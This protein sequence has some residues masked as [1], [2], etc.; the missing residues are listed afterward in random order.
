[1]DSVALAQEVGALLD[2][3]ARRTEL[4]RRGM[5]RAAEFTWAR[6]ARQTADASHRALNAG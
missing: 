1:M 5:V 3:P 4:G 6:T 2:D